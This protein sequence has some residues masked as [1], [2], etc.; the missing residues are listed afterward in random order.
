MKSGFGRLLVVALVGSVCCLSKAAEDTQRE[1]R[2]IS[3]WNV[4]INKQLLAG[5]NAPVT[6]GAMSM[7][8][9]QLDQVAAALPEKAL[10]ELQKVDLWVSPVYANYEPKAE[11]HPGE[12]WLSTEGRDTVMA[13]GIEFT[14]TADFGAELKRMPNVALHALSHAYQFHVV[15]GGDENQD[16]DAA[17]EKAQGGGTYDKVERVGADGKKSTEQHPGMASS[18]E[19][20]ATLSEAF[21][22][23]SDF[24]PHDREQLKK[25][26]P[27]MYA[28]LAKLWGVN[29]NVDAASP[30]AGK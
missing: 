19:Y 5:T 17:Y 8:K 7:L 14:D 30:A 4:H 27:A 25:H 11:F 20:F 13:G 9:K 15:E 22:A 28:L 18:Q 2:V 23:R 26:D 24:F 3:G 21:F 29:V 6:E 16:I 1:A 10:K 12:D